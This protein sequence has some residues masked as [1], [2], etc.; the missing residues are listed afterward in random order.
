MNE[1]LVAECTALNGGK[2]Y[3]HVSFILDFY[4]VYRRLGI[5]VCPAYPFVSF[6]HSE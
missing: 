5:F 3:K 2:F 4:Q 6:V 1:V